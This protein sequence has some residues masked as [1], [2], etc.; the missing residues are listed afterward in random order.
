VDGVAE[1]TIYD[2]LDARLA[3]RPRL[4]FIF[5]LA[6]GVSPHGELFSKM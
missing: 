2:A 6:Q 1:V 3:A 5:T 4:R